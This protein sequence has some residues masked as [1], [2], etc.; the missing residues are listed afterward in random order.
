[1]GNGVKEGAVQL[2]E[3]AEAI[4]SPPISSKASTWP[5]RGCPHGSL[6]CARAPITDQ[7]PPPPHT[8][9]GGDADGPTCNVSSAPSA[10][11]Q[12]PK[13]CPK[14]TEMSEGA[15]EPSSHSDLCTQ[16]IQPTQGLP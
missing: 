6:F 9:V 3:D 2:R 14:P 10:L 7:P 1:M 16:K 4:L 5:P 8:L 11:G 12:R 13:P 15:Q